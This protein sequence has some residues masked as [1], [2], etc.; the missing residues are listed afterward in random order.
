MKYKLKPRE[1]LETKSLIIS[2]YFYFYYLSDKTCFEMASSFNSIAVYIKIKI[3][4]L[5]TIL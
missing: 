2:F 5:S 4:T 3:L 1:L